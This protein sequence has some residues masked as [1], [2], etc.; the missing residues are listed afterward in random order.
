MQMEVLIRIQLKIVLCSWR[1]SFEA[2]EILR[3]DH[4]KASENQAEILQRIE[5]RLHDREYVPRGGRHRSNPRR[6]SARNTIA[7]PATCRV[8][9]IVKRN[10]HLNENY[11]NIYCTTT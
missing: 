4:E 8:S 2:T 1:S 11:K 7:I 3:Q 5:E 10:A 6:R 9:L